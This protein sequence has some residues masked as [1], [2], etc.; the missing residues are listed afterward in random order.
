MRAKLLIVPF[1]NKLQE[2]LDIQYSIYNMFKIVIKILTWPKKSYCTERICKDFFVMSCRGMK[3]DSIYFPIA[4][5][6]Q[7]FVVPI[8]L[9]Q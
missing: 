3:W 4:N 9:I 2:L 8:K 6:P 7:A 1:Q 5:K